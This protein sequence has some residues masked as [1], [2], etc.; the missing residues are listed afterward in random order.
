MRQSPG[1]TELIKRREQRHAG[2]RPRYWGI[3]G[4]L[5]LGFVLSEHVFGRHVQID[6]RGRKVVVAQ[7]SLQRREADALARSLSLARPRW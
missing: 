1:K 7:D 5:P 4:E 6:L 2:D 3:A